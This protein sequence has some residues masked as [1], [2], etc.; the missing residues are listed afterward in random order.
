MNDTVLGNASK[1]SVTP[2]LDMWRAQVSWGRGVEM[3]TVSVP[4]STE[5]LAQAWVNTVK[6]LPKEIAVNQ[7]GLKL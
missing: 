2:E 1:I 6:W 3:F 4:C 7:F 5:D